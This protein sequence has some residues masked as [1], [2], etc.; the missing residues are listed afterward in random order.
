MGGRIYYYV[1]RLGMC[2]N[3]GLSTAFEGTLT[4]LGGP[5]VG[6]VVDLRAWGGPGEFVWLGGAVPRL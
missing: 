1:T 5:G 3:M 6:N 2:S 4:L